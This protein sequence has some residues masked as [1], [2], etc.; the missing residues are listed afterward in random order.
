MSGCSETDENSG[1]RTKKDHQDDRDNLRL[2]RS[3]SIRMK[4]ENR[5]K[6]SAIGQ[7]SFGESG[8]YD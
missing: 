6:N 1:Y 4:A 8:E 5:G 3:F 7:K 2:H